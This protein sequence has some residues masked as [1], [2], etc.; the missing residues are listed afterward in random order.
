MSMVAALSDL[1]KRVWESEQEPMEENAKSHVIEDGDFR[2]DLESETAYVCD[3]RLDLTAAEFDLLRLLMPHHKKLVTPRTAFAGNE[4]AANG[5]GLGSLHALM[6]LRKK[7]DAVSP[8]RH[9]LRT[10]PWI[11]CSFNPIG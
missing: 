9:Y 7:L 8:V 11:L 4:N 1:T 3:K 10:E 2:L 5:P 6:S